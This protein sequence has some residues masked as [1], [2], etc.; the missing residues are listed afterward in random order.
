DAVHGVTT[1]LDLNAEAVCSVCG[2]SGAEPGT[3]PDICPTCQGTGTVATDQGP[4]SFSQV[5]PTCNGRGLL[6]TDKCKRC[7]GRGV[8]VTGPVGVKDGQRIRVAGRGAPGRN[9][10]PHGDLYV[11][12]HVK[13][14]AFFGRS[15]ARDLTVHVPVTFSEAA[16][17]AQVRVPTLGEPV[18]VK[19]PA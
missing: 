14:H 1:T 6:V 5:C 18:T 15:G 17:G 4:F 8:E 11:V 7:R 2:G 3:H 13:P 9:G 16:L 12:V 10:G 19:V